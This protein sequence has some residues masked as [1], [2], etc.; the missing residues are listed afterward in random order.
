MLTKKLRNIY[1]GDL[2]QILLNEHI[3]NIYYWKSLK[4]YFVN[5]IFA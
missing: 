5:K 3:N 1:S 4:L 2:E